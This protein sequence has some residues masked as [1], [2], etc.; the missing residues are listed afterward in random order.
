MFLILGVLSAPRRESD[1]RPHAFLFTG[2]QFNEVLNRRYCGGP[3]GGI[4][5]VL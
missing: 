5:K 2:F 1:Q 3:T 4:K